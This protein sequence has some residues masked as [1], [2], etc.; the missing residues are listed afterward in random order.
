MIGF[1]FF[2]FGAF[3]FYAN[4]KYFPWHYR[5]VR[6]LLPTWAGVLVFCIGAAIYLLQWGPVIGTL[7]SITAIPLA[8]CTLLF[9]LN[10]PTKYAVT[11]TLGLLYFLAI[12]LLH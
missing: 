8:C 9:L 2:V 12:D 10:L 3:P 1:L 11:F 5:S 4:S 7:I 6:G